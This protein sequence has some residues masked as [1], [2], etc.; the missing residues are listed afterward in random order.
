[1]PGASSAQQQQTTQAKAP[2]W[3]PNDK[4]S[5]GRGKAR[6]KGKQA[7]QKKYVKP[8][9]PL[10]PKGVLVLYNNLFCKYQPVH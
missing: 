4:K 9:K 6:G 8:V 7:P 1:M 10:Q 2:V 5:K 3:K